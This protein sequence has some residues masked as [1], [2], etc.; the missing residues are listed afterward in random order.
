[1]PRQDDAGEQARKLRYLASLLLQVQAKVTELLRLGRQISSPADLIKEMAPAEAELMSLISPDGIP[2]KDLDRQIESWQD[3]L[4]AAD[5]LLKV[6]VPSVNLLSVA[7]SGVTTTSS[8]IVS[9]ITTVSNYPAPVAGKVAAAKDRIDQIL[10]RANFLEQVRAEMLRLKLDQ[11]RGGQKSPLDLLND[12]AAGFGTSPGAALM[13]IRSSVH[14]T[15]AEL[16]RRRPRQQPAPNLRDKL[17]SVGTQFGI[18]GLALDHFD[19]LAAA[20]DILINQLG[21]AKEGDL[22]P[23][24]ISSLFHRSLS[25]L[26]TLLQSLDET[27]LRP[28]NAPS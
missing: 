7:S 17:N 24:Q 9:I 26:Y 4:R 19:R 6:S 5:D 21:G 20:G 12:A 11:R 23:E 22:Q 25:F 13:P 27:R 1:M 3:W 14:A 2:S 10:A 15:V 16:L 8:S 28:R 18:Q